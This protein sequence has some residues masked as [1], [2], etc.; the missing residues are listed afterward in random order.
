MLA[1]KNPI[2][3]NY[4]GHTQER[5]CCCTKYSKELI[6]LRLKIS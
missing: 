1:E 5:F 6:E 3:E 2:L 4:V